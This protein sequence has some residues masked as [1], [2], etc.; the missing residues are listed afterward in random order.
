MV[1]ADDR[2][3]DAHD[4]GIDDGFDDRFDDEAPGNPRGPSIRVTAGVVGVVVLVFIALL[5]T[6]QP[7]EN[8]PSFDIVGEPS[9]P[10]AGVSYDGATFDLDE[11]LLANRQLPP[12]EQTWVV[13]NFFASWCAPCEAEH[14]DLI[15]FDREGLLRPDGTACSTELVGITVRDDADD[16][17]DF[18]DRLG[19]DW[20]VLVGET[21]SSVVNFG[22][23]APPETVIIAP[24]GLVVQK[25]VGQTSYEQL[26]EVIPC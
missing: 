10:V 22:V 13:V 19:G 26:T 1:T 2:L 11:I 20:P 4:P 17:A 23:T 24:N 8:D 3:P 15:R 25:I 21:N 12:E 6:R 18:F 16:V 9:P 5:A 14:P 7:A